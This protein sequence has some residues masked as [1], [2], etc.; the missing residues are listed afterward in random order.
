MKAV[1]NNN[2]IKSVFDGNLECIPISPTD[3]IIDVP[4]GFTCKEG[5][6]IRC[7]DSEFKLIT[8]EE[9]ISKGYRVL[10]NTE[11]IVNHL[12]VDKTLEEQVGDGILSLSGDV[13]V[14]EGAIVSKVKVQSIKAD[15]INAKIDKLY[16]KMT[17]H[18]AKYINPATNQNKKDAALVKIDDIEAQIDVLKEQL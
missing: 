8:S 17:E 3:T 2:K 16:Q 18:I 12:I 9:M 14:F 1:I 5:D 7:W 15:R 13:E 4:Y 6:D 10:K 11:K